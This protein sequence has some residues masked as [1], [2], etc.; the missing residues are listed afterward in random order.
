[1][2]TTPT[3]LPV[4]SEKPQDLKFNTGKIDEFVTSMAQQYIDRFGQA[5]YT[6]EGLRWV[7]QQAIAE[8]GYI[9]VD[10]FQGGATLTLP[11]Q[12]LRDTSTGEYYRW[13]G[14]FPKIVPTGSTPD[15]SGGKGRG[16]WVSVGDAALR[17]DL[18]SSSGGNYVNVDVNTTLTEF[19]SSYNTIKITNGE[20][21]SGLFINTSL[22]VIADGGDFSSARVFPVLPK[23]RETNPQHPTGV[24]S[25]LN[26]ITK[27]YSVTIGTVEYWLLDSDYFD[28]SDI[29]LRAFWASSGESADYCDASI[30]AMVVA[31][32]DCSIGSGIF[33]YKNT[34]AVPAFTKL[35]GAGDTNATGYVG[36]DS[37]SQLWY[38]PDSPTPGPGMTLG[39]NGADVYSISLSDFSI[40]AVGNAVNKTIGI[41]RRT[42]GTWSSDYLSR[43]SINKVTVYD[44]ESGIILDH[45]WL[46]EL[47]RVMVKMQISGNPAGTGISIKRGTSLSARACF[48]LGGHTGYS[49]FTTYSSLLNCASDRQLSRAYLLGPGVTAYSCGSE[50]QRDGA[51]LYTASSRTYDDSA[52]PLYFDP[53]KIYGANG[54]M[55]NGNV[56][57]FAD[58]ATYSGCVEAFDCTFEAGDS[59]IPLRPRGHSSVKTYIK[60]HN[61]AQLITTTTGVK[62]RRNLSH[63]ARNISL[64]SANVANVTSSFDSVRA[65]SFIVSTVA[66]S[67]ES[68]VCIKV[69]AGQSAEIVTS[70][71]TFQ[72]SDAY[73]TQCNSMLRFNSTYSRGVVQGE[74]KKGSA[75]LTVQY[76]KNDS[77]DFASIYVLYRFSGIPAGTNILCKMKSGGGSPVSPSIALAGSQIT[78]LSM[79]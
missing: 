51:T 64:A 44:F 76:W 42:T 57:A 78:A 34:I 46:G 6:I 30:S 52:A 59:F 16:A 61:C 8:F 55:T 14:A 69:P 62:E 20:T 10:S 12:V 11:N 48:V 26:L 25:N 35:T 73:I 49:I 28:P 71:P 39:E 19:Y 58:E 29:C 36:Y 47:D 22:R 21:I 60:L 54:L 41:A 33:R 45:A 9:T 15:S 17:H 67:G 3:N 32:S 79:T 23:V 68:L 27:P 40:R 50:S 53:V 72:L 70:E 13:D 43:Y 74:L 1:M 65:Q 75:S 38:D 7:A 5:H 24:V 37:T 77:D 18:G 2:S 63:L 31:C 56:A 66:G 4:P